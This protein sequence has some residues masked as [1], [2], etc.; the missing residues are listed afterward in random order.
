M[1]FVAK[2]AKGI[3]TGDLTPAGSKAGIAAIRA[4]AAAAGRDPNTVQSFIGITLE[5]CPVPASKYLE[6]G[7]L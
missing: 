7:W 3:Y 5:L 1:A 4:Q 2:H 6:S